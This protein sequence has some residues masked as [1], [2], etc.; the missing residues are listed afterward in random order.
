M[1]CLSNCEMHWI[2][3]EPNLAASMWLLVNFKICMAFQFLNWLWGYYYLPLAPLSTCS[4]QQPYWTTNSVLLCNF[5]CLCISYAHLQLASLLNTLFF[6]SQS[7]SLIYIAI[8]QLK[9]LELQSLKST[10]H[11]FLKTWILIVPP[12]WKLGL[13]LSVL[14]HFWCRL[15]LWC[16]QFRKWHRLQF[17]E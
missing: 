4:Y 15:W 5:C 3:L 10:S 13:L 6:P 9:S 11:Y 2:F 14:S 12:I 17:K 16:I 8:S 7:Y 1:A